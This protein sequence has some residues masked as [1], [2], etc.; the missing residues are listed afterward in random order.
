MKPCEAPPMRAKMTAD[1]KK[2]LW[3]HLQD[4]DNRESVTI[5]FAMER[6]LTKCLLK[7]N[8][9]NFV[10]CAS[11]VASGHS[12]GS[13]N[14]TGAKWLGQRRVFPLVGHNGEYV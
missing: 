14:Q 11:S 12:R 7:R 2:E 10:E 6:A 5:P 1:T 8:L 3:C 4:G 9:K 13:T